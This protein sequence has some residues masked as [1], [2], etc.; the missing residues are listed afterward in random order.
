MSSITKTF[1]AICRWPSLFVAAGAAVAVAVAV[2]GVAADAAAAVVAAAAA[3]AGD[4][5]VSADV[6][7]NLRP[8]AVV[9]IADRQCC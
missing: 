1:A 3:Y 8:Q 9:R 7:R 4:A 6:M 5:A 2:P